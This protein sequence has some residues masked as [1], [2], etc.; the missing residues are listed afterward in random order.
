[1][2]K[3]V[4]RI[5]DGEKKGRWGKEIEGQGRETGRERRRGG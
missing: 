5:R 3:R 4:I 2:G 1:M